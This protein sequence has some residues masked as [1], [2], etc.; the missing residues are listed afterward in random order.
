MSRIWG[1]PPEARRGIPLAEANERVH[2]D[3]RQPTREV[4]IQA[5]KE[6]KGYRLNYRIVRPD[7]TVAH[8]ISTAR[9]AEMRN[10]RVTRMVG[11]NQEVTEQFERIAKLERVRDELERTQR[12]AGIGSLRFDLATRYNHWSDEIFRIAGQV[13]GEFE[14]TPENRYGI[15][16]PD[17]RPVTDFI[18]ESGIRREPYTVRYRMICPDGST[19]WVES[20]GS[21]E[22]DASGNVVA[23]VGAVRDL[24]ADVEREH[25][26]SESKAHLK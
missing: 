7:G 5:L 10:G 21:P 3:D 16:H 18:R 12:M 9:V 24:T 1:Y 4:G 8:I 15:Y 22:C 11:T 17:D 23:Y 14:P 2:P 26:L 20:H 6:G 25:I 19:V 13:R